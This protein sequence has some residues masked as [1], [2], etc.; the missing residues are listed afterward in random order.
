MYSSISLHTN[1]PG[2]F[3]PKRCLPTRTQSMNEYL[4]R[5][6]RIKFDNF[7]HTIVLPS[8]LGQIH[9]FT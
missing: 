7:E 4:L 8:S 9:F 5:G 3:F 2:N 6:S 1:V